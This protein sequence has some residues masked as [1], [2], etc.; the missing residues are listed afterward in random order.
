MV[1]GLWPKGAEAYLLG[2]LAFHLKAVQCS[3]FADH[4]GIIAFGIQ[5]VRLRKALGDC[6][7]V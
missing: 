6:V 5:E 2:Q 1:L 7:V 3:A 4:D